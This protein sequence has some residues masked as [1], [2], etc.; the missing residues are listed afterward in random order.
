MNGQE[1]RGGDV[2]DQ[3]QLQQPPQPQPQPQPPPPQR[4]PRCDSVNTKFCYYNNYSLSQPRYFCKTC[5]RYWTH[6]G[7]LRNIPI[8]GGCR[9]GKRNKGSSSSSS[10]SSATL[11]LG[12][13]QLQ[14]R[15]QEMVSMQPNPTTLS[16]RVLLGRSSSAAVAVPSMNPYYQGGGYLS[17]LAAIHSQ[18][19][20]PQPLFSPSSLNLAPANLGFLPPGFNAS[21]SLASPVFQSAN[22]STEVESL[23]ASDHDHYHHQGLV[24]KSVIGNNSSYASLHEWSQNSLWSTVS[25]TSIGDNSAIARNNHNDDDDNSNH[26]N[27]HAGSSS[28]SANQWPDLP[29]HGPPP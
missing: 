22:R 26:N 7:S 23:Y 17:S 19:P 1:G 3:P 4:C 16:S 29:G 15:L 24:Q 8:G 27:A 2:N 21:S 12:R 6:G 10:S 14:P 28:L 13:S 18:N 9:K 5:K 25:T 20:L 11:Q